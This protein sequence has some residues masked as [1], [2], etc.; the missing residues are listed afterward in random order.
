MKIFDIIKYEGGKDVLVW[1]YPG[2]DFNTLSQL[3]VHE[4]QEAVFFRDGRILDIFGPGR[5][6]LH[7]DN[8]P[9]LRRVVNLPFDGV[10]P[11]HC[12]VY[13]I[14]KATVMD[15]LWGTS[16]I[17]VQDA[18]Y[19]VILPVSAYGQFAVRIAD[20]KKILTSLVGTLDR[21]DEQTLRQYFKGIL[22][23]NIKGYIAGQLTRNKVSFLEIHAEIKEISAGIQG[24][25]AQEF[26][27]YGIE[28]VRFD[29]NGISVP[30]D[31]PSYVQLRRALAKRAEM[32]VVGYSYQQE[33]TFDMLD[34]AAA[35]EGA[36]SDIMGAGLGLGM[37]VNLG[38]TLGNAVHKVTET[39]SGDTMQCSKCGKIVPRGKFCSSCGAVMALRCSRC[40]RPL[41]A[42]ACFCPECGT[43]VR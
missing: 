5:Y 28:L 6:T 21:F 15:I 30:E 25:L 36:G 23:T 29:V 39:A 43:E 31:D 1:K 3:I 38:Q 34:T 37:G 22:L 32:D 40:G 12:E 19:K 10:S 7:S 11:F 33:R 42:G 26:L 13:F 2:E 24:E 27:R 9:L 20:S 18:V 41:Q 4:S 17:P 8:I 14:N 16:D 35:N